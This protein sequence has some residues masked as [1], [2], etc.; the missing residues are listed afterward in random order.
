MTANIAIQNLGLLPATTE[1]ETLQQIVEIG[2]RAIGA[3]EGALLVMESDSAGLRFAVTAG[4]DESHA[5]LVGQ[6][7]SLDS[8]VIGLAALTQNV[9]VVAAVYLDAEQEKRLSEGA[10]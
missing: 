4:G 6:H 2:I 5:E 10:E 7:L 8:G 3:D 9:Q 1:A